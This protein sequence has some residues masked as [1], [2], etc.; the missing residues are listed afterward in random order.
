MK[1]NTVLSYFSTW[2]MLNNSDSIAET[3]ALCAAQFAT[4]LLRCPP[5]PTD[6]IKKTHKK[7]NYVWKK[8]TIPWKVK[9][10][11]HRLR[12]Q[13]IKQHH[14]S[15]V[16]SAELETI[17]LFS[18]YKENTAEQFSWCTKSDT[19]VTWQKDTQV[20]P[21]CTYMNICLILAWINDKTCKLC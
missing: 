9:N 2:D 12:A 13:I 17:H 11:L 3:V 5:R 1:Q 21:T 20:S 18:C 6:I 4:V 16:L 10:V 19:S 7:R 14:T 8:N 15:L